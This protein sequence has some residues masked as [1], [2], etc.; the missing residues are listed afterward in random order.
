[1]LY[2]IAA[3]GSDLES[4]C[5]ASDAIMRTLMPS[6][7]VGQKQEA[8]GIGDIDVKAIERNMKMA[9]SVLAKAFGG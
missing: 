8:E 2:V 5:K 1:M 6:D 9:E 4:V 7:W 3:R